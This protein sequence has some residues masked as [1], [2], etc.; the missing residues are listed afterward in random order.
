MVIGTAGSYGIGGAVAGGW[1]LWDRCFA[2][3][4]V[5]PDSIITS[6]QRATSA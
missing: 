1:L 2:D 3:Q 4:G 6:R 5:R